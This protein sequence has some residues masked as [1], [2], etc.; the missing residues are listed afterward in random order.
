MAAA[1]RSPRAHQLAACGDQRRCAADRGPA[2]RAGPQCATPV[3]G[4]AFGGCR[5]RARAGG[6]CARHPVVPRIVRSSPRTVFRWR[7]QVALQRAVAHSAQRCGCRSRSLRAAGSRSR[8]NSPRETRCP[9]P[10]GSAPPSC[11]RRTCSVPPGARCSDY[12]LRSRTAGAPSSTTSRSIGS[13]GSAPPPPPED[14][15]LA[16]EAPGVKLIVIV[17]DVLWAPSSWRLVQLR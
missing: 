16:A 10:T 8:W 11:H 6:A 12:C 7:R 2:L 3:G 5:D 9:T 13:N 4:S 1:D 17:C 14:G 15:G